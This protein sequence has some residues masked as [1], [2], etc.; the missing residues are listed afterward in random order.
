MAHNRVDFDLYQRDKNFNNKTYQFFLTSGR[1][2]DSQKTNNLI[3]KIKSKNFKYISEWSLQNYDERLQKNYWNAVSIIYHSYINKIYRD[4]THIG[5]L[6]YDLK[7]E[8]DKNVSTDEAI[9]QDFS[10]TEEVNKKVS[11]NLGSRFIVLPSV[12]HKLGYLDK[13]HNIRSFGKHWLNFFL[14]D[15]NKRYLCNHSYQNILRDYSNILVPTQQSFICDIETFE[16]IGEYVSYFVNTHGI[17][18]SSNYQPRASTILERCIGMFILLKI[19]PE[20]NSF[21][22]PLIHTHASN[23]KY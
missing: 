20:V 2:K 16:Q 23:G 4:K 12:R 3:E 7:F 18:P 5:F 8:I 17:T 21:V 14:E 11:S 9:S 10:F 19:L 1:A 15:Y 22:F 13:Q 6:E